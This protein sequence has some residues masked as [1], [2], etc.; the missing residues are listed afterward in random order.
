VAST[1]PLGADGAPLDLSTLI[2]SG[3]TEHKD[4][5]WRGVLCLGESTAESGPRCGEAEEAKRRPALD[6]DEKLGRR[7][8]GPVAPS[9]ARRY[10][11][12]RRPPH[13]FPPALFA[14][15]WTEIPLTVPG[16]SA[17]FSGSESSSR[18]SL[19]TGTCAGGAR[20]GRRL[21]RGG[22]G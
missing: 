3:S 15:G 8:P 1:T 22:P 2:R 6:L 17:I 13:H 16:R 14:P 5:V 12:L 10:P 7:W 11:A 21:A 18:F 9:S 4:P 19:P 20:G